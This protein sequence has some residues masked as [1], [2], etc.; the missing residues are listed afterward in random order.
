M[1]RVTILFT[2][3]SIENSSILVTVR[4]QETERHKICRCAPTGTIA[5]AVLWP[6]LPLGT[7]YNFHK[8]PE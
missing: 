2:Y 6:P 8:H 7:A 4:I 1:K 3:C 5:A